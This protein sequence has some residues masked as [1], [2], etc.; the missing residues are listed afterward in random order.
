MFRYNPPAAPERSQWCSD[1]DWAILT[2]LHR[3]QVEAG[4][5][6]HELTRKV[7]P[8][9]VGAGLSVVVFA[10]ALWYVVDDVLDALHLPASTWYA[11]LVALGAYAVNRLTISYVKRQS[12]EAEGS[13]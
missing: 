13:E 5:R 12:K 3:D 7:I 1:E 9:L 10:G 4:R 11:V 2:R 8:A 6:E